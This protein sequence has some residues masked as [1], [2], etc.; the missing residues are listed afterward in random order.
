MRTSLLGRLEKLEKKRAPEPVIAYRIG[1]LK[2][3]PKDFIGER[4]VAMVKRG[5]VRDNVEWCEFEERP[6]PAPVNQDDGIPT[7]CLSESDMR[8]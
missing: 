6:G 2:T 1:L 7:I 5:D 8:L 3:L 4:H